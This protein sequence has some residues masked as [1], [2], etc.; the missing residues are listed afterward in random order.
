MAQITDSARRYN[1]QYYADNKQKCIDYAKMWAEANPD[2]MFRRRKAK[3]ANRTAKHLGVS[4][5]LVVADIDKLVEDNSM[6]CHYC[7]L[8]LNDDK[9]QIDHVIPMRDKGSNTL[10]NIVICCKNCNE[11]KHWKSKEEFLAKKGND[12]IP[13]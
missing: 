7:K 13:R 10:D 5:R 9:W 11:Q 6:I 1:T 2:R 8:M 3:Y 12:G 4:G